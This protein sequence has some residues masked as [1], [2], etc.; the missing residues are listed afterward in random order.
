MLSN[1]TLGSRN[2]EPPYL[3][4]DLHTLVSRK[5]LEAGQQRQNAQVLA[6]Q[7]ALICADARG[8]Q[9]QEFLMPAKKGDWGS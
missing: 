7:Q 3:R 9:R 2:E 6:T 1:N 5:L 4:W 8:G